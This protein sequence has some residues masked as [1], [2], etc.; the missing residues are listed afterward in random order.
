MTNFN[1]NNAVPAPNNNP[2]VDQPD[3][4][5]N[6]QSIELL[7]EVDHISFRTEDGGTHKQVTFSS[8]NT[9]GAQ[10]DPASTLYTAS[11]T[12]SSVADILFKNQNGIFKLDCI[13]AF[14]VFTT[15]NANGAI[16]VTAGFNVDSILASANGATNTITLT[17]GATTG[18]TV[19]VLALISN[20]NTPSWAFAADT[21]TLTISPGDTAAKIMTFVVMQ[22]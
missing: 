11:G 1:Y 10:A 14:G 9:P 4:L 16:A 3:M 17:T 18:T 12:A 22:V 15:Q 20:G 6:T 7:L 19:G 21:L 2:S 13:K 5:I 8:K